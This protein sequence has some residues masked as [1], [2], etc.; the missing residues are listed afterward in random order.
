MVRPVPRIEPVP[1]VA[2][3]TAMKRVT[4]LG[5]TGSIGCN[6]VDLIARAPERFAVEAVTGNHNVQL[7]A[8]QARRLRAKLAVVADPTLYGQ[9]RDALAGSGIEAA[10]G[11]AAIVAHV[12]AHDAA[13]REAPSVSLCCEDVG[14][15]SI[16]VGLDADGSPRVTVNGETFVRA[17]KKG[18]WK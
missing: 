16:S 4:I 13:L 7:L 12:R 10:A 14:S 6:T 17:M 9:L 5:S 8:E 18:V 11:D 2:A 15:Y 3:Q 1:A